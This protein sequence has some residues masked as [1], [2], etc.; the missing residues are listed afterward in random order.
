[1]AKDKEGHGS[2]GYLN[3]AEHHGRNNMTAGKGAGYTVE[4]ERNAGRNEFATRSPSGEKLPLAHRTKVGADALSRRD[5]EKGFKIPMPKDP[6]E[7]AE[8]EAAIAARKARSGG[9]FVGDE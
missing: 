6:K 8:Y 9:K 7:R 5:E 4:P 3:S 2:E 1:M